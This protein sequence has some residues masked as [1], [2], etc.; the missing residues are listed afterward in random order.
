MTEPTITLSD[1]SNAALREALGKGLND[2][3]DEALGYSDR[4]PLELSVTDPETGAILGGIAGRTSLGLLF[5][6]LVYLSPGLRHGGLGSRLLA[7]AE[8]EAVR[9][10]CGAG[11]LFTITIQA[12][13]FYRKHGWQEFGRIA[14]EPPGTA[15]V[16]FQKTLGQSCAKDT[17]S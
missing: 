14:C 15:R 8:A 17:I 7:M 2:Y 12:P 3:N 13:E 11:V 16:W 6:D 5:I 10:G 1:T 9:R 4:L